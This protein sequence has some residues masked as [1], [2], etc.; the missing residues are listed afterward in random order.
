MFTAD[1]ASAH[2]VEKDVSPLLSLTLTSRADGIAAQESCQIVHTWAQMSAALTSA[3]LICLKVCTR[4][5]LPTRLLSF[6]WALSTA[7]DTPQQTHGSSCAC[8]NKFKFFF[9]E[10][11]WCE[12]EAFNKEVLYKL[13]V[14][15][16][17]YVHLACH[18][19]HREH[20]GLAGFIA[21][22]LGSSITGVKLQIPS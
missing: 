11:S 16:R 15:A 14:P 3:R 1:S 4:P 10:L 5:S 8:R 21:S 17:A 2:I 6:T 7:Q 18:V 22:V 20:C 13:L 19:H 9:A 12:Q